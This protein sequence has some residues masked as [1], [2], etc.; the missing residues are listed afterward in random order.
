[1]ICI[2]I[3]YTDGEMYKTNISLVYEMYVKLWKDEKP[4]ETVKMRFNLK[5]V[6]K[7]RELTQYELAKETGLTI[8]AIQNYERGTKKQYSHEV[9]EKLCTILKCTPSDL[10]VLE[11]STLTE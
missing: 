8:A 11:T 4:M 1:M 10:F 5:E 7:S 3:T 2:F 6:R 9:L